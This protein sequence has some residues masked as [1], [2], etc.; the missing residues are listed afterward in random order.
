M[1]MC[2]GI[3]WRSVGLGCGGRGFRGFW[4]FLLEMGVDW[5]C[6]DDLMVWNLGWVVMELGFCNFC[7]V[8]FDLGGYEGREGEEL[9]RSEEE[10]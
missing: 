1:L 8:C 7:V 4:F 6:I 9:V 5:G 3:F 2:F 10:S